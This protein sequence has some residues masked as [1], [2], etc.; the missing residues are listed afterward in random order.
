MPSMVK[1]GFIL[2][3]ARTPFP[4][5]L[6]WTRRRQLAEMSQAPG[7]DFDMDTSMFIEP[8]QFGVELLEFKKKFNLK[9][10][11]LVKILGVPSYPSF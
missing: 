3:C 1:W 2:G 5:L 6:R 10:T 8:T 7:D 9:D 11:E 4:L